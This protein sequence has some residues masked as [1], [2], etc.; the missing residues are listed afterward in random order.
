MNIERCFNAREGATRKDDSLPW[1]MMNEKVPTGP[2]KGMITDQ[3]ML[4][5]LLDDYYSLHGWDSASAVPRYET[6]EK[7]GIEDVCGDI[8]V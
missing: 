6:I 7:L 8:V 3:E 4:D 5:G 2:N 1:R